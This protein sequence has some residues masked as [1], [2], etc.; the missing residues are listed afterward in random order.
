[1]IGNP[2]PPTRARPDAVCLTLFAHSCHYTAYVREV[3]GGLNGEEMCRVPI[4]LPGTARGPLLGL[5]EG[6]GH[7]YVTMGASGYVLESCHDS[8]PA[9][10]QLQRGGGH[11][12]KNPL[13]ATRRYRG[14]FHAGGRVVTCFEEI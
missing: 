6:C 12:M 1:M 7:R 8:F 13:M 4:P 10:S 2:P 9:A 5:K 14:N 3:G 11:T